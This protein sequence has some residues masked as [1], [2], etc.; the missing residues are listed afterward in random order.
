MSLLELTVALVALASLTAPHLVSLRHASPPAAITVWLL[1]LL[2]RAVVAVSLATLALIGL[3]DVGV[4]R[5]LLDWCW[6][7]LLPDVPS[8]MGFGEHPIA[9]AVV[10]VPALVLGASLLWLG[11]R[12][13]RADLAL[14]RRLAGAIGRGPLGSTI[15]SDDRIVFAVTSVGRGRVIVSDRALGELDEDELA[16][17]LTH[18]LAHLRRRH[19]PLLLVGSVLEAVARPLPGTRTAERELRFHIE[20][21]ADRYT[22]RTLHDPLSLASAICKA[23]GAPG[24]GL[25]GLGGR[26]RVTQRLEE[27]LEGSPTPRR[28]QR[29]AGAMAAILVAVL[30]AAG[31]AL[32]QWSFGNGTPPT[33]DDHHG[34]SHTS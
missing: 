16:A 18:E 4:V 34:C 26:G 14:R 27:L 1:A 5:A 11:V 19:R 31:L 30:V 25:A 22:V 33:G 23:A 2:V 29:A 10:A 7:E 28:S 32:P 9:H 3:S 13:V 21:D 24:T 12:F 15:V 17:G 8:Q 20:R 6:H